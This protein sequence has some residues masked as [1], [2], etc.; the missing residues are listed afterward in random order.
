[1]DTLSYAVYPLYLLAS[2]LLS[3]LGILF[4]PFARLGSY[5]LHLTLLPLRILALFEPLY[6]FLGTA[7]LIGITAG[8]VLH[9]MSV[10]IGRAL[11]LSKASGVS[12]RRR[13]P[14][15]LQDLKE[16]ASLR[17]WK[18]S[19]YTNKPWSL[20][21]DEARR[22]PGSSS[23]NDPKTS[24]DYYAEWTNSKDRK[25]LADGGLFPSTILEEEDDS[26]CSDDSEN[27]KRQ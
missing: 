21:R 25:A 19:R 9:L 5:V 27:E 3:L 18:S 23:A 1:M 16:A 7:M 24:S 10:S 8:L 14:K 4:T 13:H 11:R 12:G 17:P 20:D 26:R 2:G 22:S 6:I 15:P